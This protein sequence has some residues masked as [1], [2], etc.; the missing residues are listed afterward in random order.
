MFSVSFMM[1]LNKSQSFHS[2]CF[3]YI[4]QVTSVSH[5]LPSHIDFKADEVMCVRLFIHFMQ[6]TFFSSVNSAIEQYCCM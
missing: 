2:W 5:L 1:L 4:Y 3:F 6:G